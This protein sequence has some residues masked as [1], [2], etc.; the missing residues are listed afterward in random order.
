MGKV[1]DLAA[2]VLWRGQARAPLIHRGDLDRHAVGVWLRR[3]V[4]A[5]RGG[6][7]SKL[8]DASGAGRAASRMRVSGTR[9]QSWTEIVS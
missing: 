6:R 4:H 1:T 3:P 2:G 7:G 8:A 9:F 5:E